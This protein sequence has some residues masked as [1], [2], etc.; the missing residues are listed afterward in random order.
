MYLLCVEPP[1]G[2]LPDI[3]KIQNTLIVN[4]GI[5][6]VWY[7]WI[8]LAQSET[9]FNRKEYNSEKLRNIAPVRCSQIKQHRNWIIME[10][11]QKLFSHLVTESKHDFWPNGKGFVL[12]RT[13]S[14]DFSA[15]S[16]QHTLRSW[17]LRC[18]GLYIP[19]GQVPENG[20]M[21]DIIWNINV[22][23]LLS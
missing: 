11:D 20:G 5:I 9:E 22:R 14:A 21:W 15:V 3:L 18:I 17:K 16:V 4:S 10:D 13:E 1:E 7:P 12:G 8:P 19:E 6:P 2:G 23:S